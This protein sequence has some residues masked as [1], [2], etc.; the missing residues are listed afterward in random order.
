MVS[1]TSTT[2]LDPR[3]AAA[4][5]RRVIEANPDANDPEADQEDAAMARAQRDDDGAGD[6]ASEDAEKTRADEPSI[7]DGMAAHRISGVTPPADWAPRQLDEAQTQHQSSDLGR[8]SSDA[9]TASRLRAA[10]KAINS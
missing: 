3:V 9:A 5:P 7:G 10:L 2:I 8:S 1:I 6:A 4:N